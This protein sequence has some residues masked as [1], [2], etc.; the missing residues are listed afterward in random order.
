M[1]GLVIVTHEQIGAELLKVAA[2]LRD[3]KPERKP[4]CKFVPIEMNIN[5]DYL[6][7]IISDAIKAMDDGRG[8]LVMTDMFGGT[9]SN[10][11]LSFLKDRKVEVLAGVNLPLLLHALELIENSPEMTLEVLADEVAQCGQESIKDGLGL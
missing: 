8:V 10:I 11:T 3:D 1:I 5:P 7:E 9:P 4:K 6:E 2:R